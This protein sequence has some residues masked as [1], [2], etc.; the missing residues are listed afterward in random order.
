MELCKGVKNEECK[1][2]FQ[3]KI[4][5]KIEYWQKALNMLKNN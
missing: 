4:N 5:S 3:E 1:K 2:T